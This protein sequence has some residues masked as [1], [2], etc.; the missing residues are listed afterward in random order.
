[1][2]NE[3]SANLKLYIPSNV[4][5]RLEF[6]KGFGMQELIVVII[7]MI[8]LLP[9][10]FIVYKINGGYLVPVLIE[11][12]GVAGM[13]ISSTKDDNNLC[14]IDQLKYMIEFVKMQKKYKYQYYDRWRE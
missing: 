1:M 13:V 3:R 6:F 10:S 8:A 7:V 2:S 5:T 4:K 12:I 14:V 9:I 11:F